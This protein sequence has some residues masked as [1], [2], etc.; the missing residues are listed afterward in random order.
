MKLEDK[1]WAWANLVDLAQ[2]AA[3]GDEWASSLID[4]LLDDLLAP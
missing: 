3:S 4:A 1:Q 2:L